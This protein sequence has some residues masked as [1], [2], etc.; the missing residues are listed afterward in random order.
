VVVVGAGRVVE[1]EARRRVGVVVLAR[2]VDEVGA[3]ATNTADFGRSGCEP[4]ARSAA[5]NTTVTAVTAAKVP[6]VLP[7]V[8]FRRDLRAMQIGRHSPP[9]A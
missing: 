8:W 6:T 3:A 2:G 4:R 1:V 5:T 7:T 9:A